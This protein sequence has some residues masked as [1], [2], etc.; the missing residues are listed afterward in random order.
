MQWLAL[1]QIKS[2]DAGRRLQAIEALSRVNDLKAVVA[3]IGALADPVT[4][5]RVAAV[6]AIG[7]L[8]DERC[9]QPLLSV[10]RDP[11]AQVRE[12]ALVS[13]KTIG[14]VSAVPYLI[15]FLSD[16]A[17]AV[18]ARA[19]AA[20]Q[21]FGWVPASD[22]D[23]VNYYIAAGQFMKAAAVGPAALEPLLAALSDESGSRRRAVTEA[24]CEIGEKRAIVAVGGMLE[25]PDSG[26]RVSALSALGRTHDPS[27]APVLLKQLEHPDKNV[28]ASALDALDKVGYKDIFPVLVNAL[29]DAHWNVRVVAATSL[30]RS[31]DARA[32]KPLLEVLSEPDT[33]VRQVV[34]EAI[35][36]LRD[37]RAIEPLILA[38][39]DPDSG[40]RQA[41]NKALAQIDS[42]WT[43]SEPAQHTLPALKKALKDGD[44]FVRQTAADLLNR[45]FNIRQCEPSLLAEVN[46]ETT[47]REHAV[48]V[49]ASILWDND[50][51]LRFAGVWALHQ[52][53]DARAATPLSAKLEDTDYCVRLAAEIAVAELG[54]RENTRAL[55]HAAAAGDNW[56]SGPIV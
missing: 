1:S 47:R 7:V 25:D 19:A 8:R 49:L 26:V 9:V 55:G 30:G 15:P 33:D 51:L 52:I 17:P 28:R 32:L 3:L 21:H 4:R 50:P 38:Q 45:I 12:A 48:D 14:H 5:V 41:I 37:P 13:L 31:G 24:L 40:V 27:F 36:K 22:A 43:K 16:P 20:L 6:Q 44:Y 46:A 23:R 34:A 29:K 10:L 53:G 18:R 42:D 39:L 54:A 35:G 11:E 2:S 56:G